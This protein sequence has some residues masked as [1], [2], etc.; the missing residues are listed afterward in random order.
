MRLKIN[1]GKSKAT[2]LCRDCETEGAR[3]FRLSGDGSKTNA[4]IETGDLES[5]RWRK[6]VN[7]SGSIDEEISTCRR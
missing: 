6:T 5:T 2:A 3:A 4:D 7:V 1:V